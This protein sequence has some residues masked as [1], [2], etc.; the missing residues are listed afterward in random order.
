MKGEE[1]DEP[2]KYEI[3][4]LEDF[5]KVPENR[6]RTCLAEVFA[7][8]ADAH[9]QGF[10]VESAIWVDDGVPWVQEVT[11]GGKTFANPHHPSGP[12]EA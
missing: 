1:M 4:S 3:R 6:V 11:V 5:W 10:A 12:R 2:K 9:S 7:H 8:V